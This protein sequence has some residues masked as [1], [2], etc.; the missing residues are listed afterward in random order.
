MIMI[1]DMFNHALK[2]KIDGLCSELSTLLESVMH[3]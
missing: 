1:G 3:F 2:A